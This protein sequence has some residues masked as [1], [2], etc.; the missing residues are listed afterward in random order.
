M[1]AKTEEGAGMN[2]P[3]VPKYDSSLVFW[4]RVVNMSSSR[5]MKFMYWS[6]TCIATTSADTALLE[7]HGKYILLHTYSIHNT[8]ETRSEKT[9]TKNSH[10]QSTVFINKL[11]IRYMY[12][13][14]YNGNLLY[15]INF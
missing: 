3:D 7:T 10:L 1:V 5:E 2:M 11:E 8:D 15:Q 14:C 6:T 9:T 4:C 13:V 12:L